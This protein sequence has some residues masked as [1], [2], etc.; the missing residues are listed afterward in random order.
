MDNSP[1]YD[2]SVQIQDIN[3]RVL[4][5]SSLIFCFLRRNPKYMR[6][7]PI[8]ATVCTIPYFILKHF[9]GW[10]KIVFISFG[11]FEL[12]YFTYFLS[13]VYREKKAKIALWIL[14]SICLVFTASLFLMNWFKP[15]VVGANGTFILCEST[16]MILGCLEYIR[17]LLVKRD[18]PIL[19][20]EPAFW[21]VCGTLSYFLALGPTVIFS[22]LEFVN[23]NKEV[24]RDIWSFNNFSQLISSSFY[25]IGMVCTYKRRY[26]WFS[27][28]S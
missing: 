10:K 18:V 25:I 27:F 4:A 13:S 12:V 5:V 17:E 26:S 1:L 23:G 22:G 8:Y 15:V 28:S 2:L 9:P 21:M 3:E 16:I 7:F 6:S 24:A 14:T 11:I 19:S 20:R